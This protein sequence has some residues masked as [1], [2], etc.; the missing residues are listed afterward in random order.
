MRLR[1]EMVASM[2]DED[3]VAACGTGDLAG[4]GAMFD[5]FHEAV[6]R[7]VERMPGSDG[8]DHEDVVQVTFLEARIAAKRFRGGSSVQRW[9]FSIAANLVRYELRCERR[10]R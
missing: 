9:L 1:H 5:R 7:L 6:H 4:L 3:L 2:S 10:R 8:I